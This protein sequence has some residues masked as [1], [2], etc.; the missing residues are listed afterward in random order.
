VLDPEVVAFLERHNQV[1]L[2]THRADGWPTGYPMVGTHRDGG[3][4]FSTY[5]AS[6]KV[7][8]VLRDGAA[9]CLVVPRD[10]EAEPTCL[11][12]R[13]PASLREPGSSRA[14]RQAGPVPPVPPEVAQQVARRLADG[15]RALLRVE[16]ADTRWIG[17]PP[18]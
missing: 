3:I 15:K 11:W 5:R 8:R 14:S 7:T 10:A 17:L 18:P 2:L 4:E 9:S 16:I 1:F 6:A 12:L 13:G